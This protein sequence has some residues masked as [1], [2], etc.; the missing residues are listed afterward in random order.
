MRTFTQ[1]YIYFIYKHF[2]E[3]RAELRLTPALSGVDFT[4]FGYSIF[5]WVDYLKLLNYHHF[6]PVVPHPL[7]LVLVCFLQLLGAHAEYLMLKSAEEV[8]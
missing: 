4:S 3:L 5:K 1:I 7:S 6:L 8:I 2:C